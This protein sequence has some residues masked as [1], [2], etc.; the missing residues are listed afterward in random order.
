MQIRL[1][2]CIFMSTNPKDDMD[3]SISTTFKYKSKQVNNKIIGSSL[4]KSF[5]FTINVRG[6]KVG[7][8]EESH[9][10]I[11]VKLHS[12]TSKAQCP[13]CHQYSK[14][15]HSH[16]T[17]HLQDIPVY[18]RTLLLEVQVGKYRCGNPGC[19]RKIF[20]ERLPDICHPYA[21]NTLS[22][23]K[24]IL[25]VSLNSSA[26]RASSLLGL[27]HITSSAS[28][29]LRLLHRQGKE[30]PC[31]QS[32]YVGIDDFAWKK[33]HIYMSVVVDHLT[34][35]PVAVLNE[36]GGET[37]EQ[38]FSK[39]PQIQYITR[40]R[41]QSFIEAI[42]GSLPNATQ[43]CDR[44][45]L[46]KNMIDTAT[47]QV[48]ALLKKP[49][50]CLYHQY[51]T[52]AE[53]EDMIL[54]AIFHMGKAQHSNKLQTYQKSLK[55]KSLGYTILEIANELGK[56][57]RQIY[58]IMH[59]RKLSSYMNPDQKLALKHTQELA[60][61]ISNGHIDV[62]AIAKQMKGVLGTALIAKITCTL[63]K[64]YKDNRRQVR[65]TNRKVKDEN[66]S[67]KLS[68]A[69]IRKLLLGDSSN[70]LR[71]EDQPS[72][73]IKAL[74]D[75]CREFRSIINGKG[76]VNDLE[77]WIL[78]TKK[79]PNKALRNF[80]YG[81]AKEKEA[82]QAAIDIPLSNG[83]AEGTVNKIKGI[84]RQMY[85]RAGISLLRA[86]ILYESG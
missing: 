13:Y 60:G 81:I 68:K 35:K 24:Q 7:L 80:A 65:Q 27:L 61:I 64:K 36:R 5:R 8:I 76:Q 41:G 66:E 59:N 18:D 28:S 25:W 21:R 57:T 56:T 82:I 22:A 9:S 49:S 6:L 38:W 2:F 73:Q 26:L 63:R 50:K 58:L 4:F 84:K 54:E 51:P 19:E 52:K 40:D 1:V 42:N 46:I 83:R 37:V 67:C 16:Y 86:K 30:N 71:Q 15:K 20:A 3:K 69:Q 72:I 44:F 12:N 62:Y 70:T 39:N 10:F 17:R 11:R 85:N 53:A 74:V 47:P 79:S 33:G 55:L 31:C 14:H 29:C 78:K 75:L 34:G 48:A 43:I 32:T 77:K 45:H 23:E